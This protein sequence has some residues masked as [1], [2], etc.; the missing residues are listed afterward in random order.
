MMRNRPG[1]ENYKRVLV[2][3]DNSVSVLK[4]T[5]FVKST[6]KAMSSTYGHSIAAEYPL[7]ISYPIAMANLK[8]EKKRKKRRE[9]VPLK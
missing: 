7:H 4:F 2:V 9:N 6:N 8:K 1:V 5:L 3:E